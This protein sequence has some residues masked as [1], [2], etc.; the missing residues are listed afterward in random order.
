MKR[1]AAAVTLGALLAAPLSAQEFAEPKSGTKFPVK[2][3]GMTLLG[4][5]LR[6]RTFLK[7]R[8]YAIGLYVGDA[9]I[10]GPLAADKGQIGSPAFYKKLVEGDFKKQVTLKFLRDLDADQIQEAMREALQGADKARVD[11]F[12]GYFPAITSAQECVIR[13]APGGTLETVM[14][15]ANKP[16][17]VDK[18]FATAVFAIWL[19]D[20]PVQEDVKKALVSRAGEVIR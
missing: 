9:A 20:T 8:V 4:A 10:S 2:A 16:P 5:G 11:T 7:V 17:I 12:V 6:T 15:G 18:A 3:D 1:T 19:G 14:A 13:W